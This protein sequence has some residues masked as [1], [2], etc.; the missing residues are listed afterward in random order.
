MSL[1]HRIVVIASAGILW[2][3][4]EIFIG[5]VF[6]HYHIPMRGGSL[7]ALGIT[8]L[9][10]S[11]LLYDRFGTSTGIGLIAGGLR[12]LV[13][14]VYICHMVAI[15]LE[16]FAFDTA[17]AALRAGKRK[18]IRRIWLT[19]L[20]GIYSGLFAFGLLSIYVFKFGKWVAGGITGSAVWT[21]R[22]GSFS[23]LL[24]VGLTPLAML[25]AERLERAYMRKTST[26]EVKI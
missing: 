13:P 10:I 11:R 14:K 18:S 25:I 20:I 7:T 17:W 16:A 22:S 21:L 6:Y 19:S 1:R 15:T 5:D 2:G 9:I 26:P 12:C 8:I 4:S 3:L 23:G 24:L